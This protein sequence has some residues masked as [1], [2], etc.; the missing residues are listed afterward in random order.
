MKTFSALLSLVTVLALGTSGARADDYTVDTRT[1]IQQ[2]DQSDHTTRYD[3][4]DRTMT[5]TSTTMDRNSDEINDRDFS[6]SDRDE[7]I[8]DTTNVDFT[9]NSSGAEDNPAYNIYPGSRSRNGLTPEPLDKRAQYEQLAAR[10]NVSIYRDADES[11]AWRS[12]AGMSFR[13]EVVSINRANN[14]IVV[15]NEQGATGV[16][17]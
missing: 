8:L 4:V 9:A 6:S 12:S 17:L 3:D 5:R 2:N 7:I 11:G 15:R 10:S 13:G 1:T 16:Y 14:Q